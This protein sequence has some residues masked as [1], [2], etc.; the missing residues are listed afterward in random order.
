[1]SLDVRHQDDQQRAK[2]IDRLHARADEIAVVS[3]IEV[4]WSMIQEHNS[5]PC[6]P[7]LTQRLA[8]A[9]ESLGHP[10]WRLPSG[11][12]HDGVMLSNLTPIAML[13]VRCKSGIS[14]N[15]AEAVAEEDVGI[16]IDV[17]SRFLELLAE[18]SI[19]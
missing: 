3:G 16:A 5:V 2:A 12:G 15:P 11:A 18:M 9:I 10:V 1:M 4:G 14:H 7:E 6:S 19:T 8:Q 17:L 13:F